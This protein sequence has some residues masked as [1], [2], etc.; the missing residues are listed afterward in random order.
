M[1]ENLSTVISKVFSCSELNFLCSN[2]LFVF[3]IVLKYTY[4]RILIMA[5]VMVRNKIIF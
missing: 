3:T 4:L 2:K 5:E 1:N